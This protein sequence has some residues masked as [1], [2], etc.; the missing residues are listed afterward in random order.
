MYRIA[1][2]IPFVLSACGLLA[3]ETITQHRIWTDKRAMIVPIAIAVAMGAARLGLLRCRHLYL[4]LF[5]VFIAKLSETACHL[6]LDYAIRHRDFP[7]NATLASILLLS[8]VANIV[9][10]LVACMR[11]R[12]CLVS[13]V[14]TMHIWCYRAVVASTL[15]KQMINGVVF[16]KLGEHISIRTSE[17]L[18]SI[19]LGCELVTAILLVPL[20]VIVFCHSIRAS[21]TRAPRFLVT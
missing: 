18:I 16:T 1:I 5:I 8:L 6:T 21:M 11:E 7:T 15:V 3:I 4:A 2:T 20:S 19:S 13:D 17:L 10:I 14:F 9:A 12:H